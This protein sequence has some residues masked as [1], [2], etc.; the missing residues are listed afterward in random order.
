MLVT[1][2]PIGGGIMSTD[3]SSIGI[4]FWLAFIVIVNALWIGMDLWLKA[5]HHEFLTVEFREGL[6]NQ[7]WGPVLCFL[8]AGTVAAFIWHMFSNGSGVPSS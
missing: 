5:H 1:H 8:I 3:E 6:R 4:Y 2:L 7:L